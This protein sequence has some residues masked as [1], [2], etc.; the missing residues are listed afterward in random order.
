[1]PERQDYILRLLEELNQFLA[2]VMRFRR[3]GSHD[4]ALLTLLQAQERLFARPAEQFMALPVAQQVHLLVVDESAAHARQKCLAYATLLVEAAQ[5]YDARTQPALAHGAY[6]LAM[7]VILLAWRQPSPADD[8][9]RFA[10]LLARVP[11]DELLPEIKDG[12]I[13]GIG[14]C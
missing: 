10:A 2:E 14:E 6:Q 4:A 9:A 13:H 11:P 12:L 8:R 3:A 5:I 1:M 7:E